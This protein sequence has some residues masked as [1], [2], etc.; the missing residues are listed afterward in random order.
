MFGYKKKFM[1]A[2]NYTGRIV[3]PKGLREALGINKGDALIIFKESP[4][5]LSMWKKERV[6]AE[7]RKAMELI[8]R[9]KPTKLFLFESGI[10]FVEE[11]F[12][13]FIAKDFRKFASI[14]ELRESSK[15]K[16]LL[17]VN[18][19]DCVE[20]WSKDVWD[21]LYMSQY[22]NLF[23]N[24]SNPS[25]TKYLFL[26]EHQILTSIRIN[27]LRTNE[28][29]TY[30]KLRSLFEKEVGKKIVKKIAKEMITIQNTSAKKLGDNQ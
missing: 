26:W 11:G 15:K 8:E 14:D 5:F 10:S 24:R 29:I 19:F 13:I 30:E 28:E 9:T 3:I 22:R 23:K 6:D 21:Q 27:L 17:L 12:R 18:H 4:G 1:A 20:I 2:I 25:Y 16:I 7:S